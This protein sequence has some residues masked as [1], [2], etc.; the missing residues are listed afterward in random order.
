MA[1]VHCSARSYCP[2]A[3]N[4]HTTSQKT[5]PVESG[6]ISP[7][8]V[9]TAA[10]F[11]SSRPCVTSPCRIRVRAS[12]T[13][14]RAAAA[15]IAPRTDVNGPASPVTSNVEVAG[16]QSFV[17]AHRGNPGVHRSLDI[18]VE[19]SLRPREPP[20]DGSQQCRVEE[21]MHRDAD[22]SAGGS[23][24]DRQPARLPHG[25]APN[26]RWPHR[27]DPRRMRRQP[28]AAGRLRRAEWSR[29][30]RRGADTRVANRP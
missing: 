3:C 14:P 18:G 10:S 9:A 1:S 4:A 7:E 30:L 19:Q 16:Q 11:S 20:T 23:R 27:D 8:T 6:S 17:T 5:T 15:A 13:R 29:R 24:P 25:R 22:R 12:A 21:Q 2:S 26:P 28:E